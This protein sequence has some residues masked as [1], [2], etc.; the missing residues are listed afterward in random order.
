MAVML[1]G[2]LHSQ[3]PDTVEG[4]QRLP[5]VGQKTAN[6]VASI[7]FGRQVI[8]VDTH[9]FRIAHRL[10]LVDDSADTP[11]KTEKQ[12]ERN[13]PLHLRAKAHHWLILHGRY[14]CTARKPHCDHCGLAQWCKQMNKM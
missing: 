6:V 12:L 1:A 10:G 14:V 7:V 4:L 2:E 5:G 13:I 9:V 3:L 11:E 8:A